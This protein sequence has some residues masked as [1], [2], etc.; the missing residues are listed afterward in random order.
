MANDAPIAE[1]FKII[2]IPVLN[3]FLTEQVSNFIKI[4]HSSDVHSVLEF[5]NSLWG[6]RNQVET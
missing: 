3:T 1:P 6:A 2:C 5:E 4:K